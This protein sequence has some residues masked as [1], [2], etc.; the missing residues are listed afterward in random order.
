MTGALYN[1]NVTH[2][3]DLFDKGNFIADSIH[4]LAE[5]IRM[6][7]SFTK[8]IPVTSN[9]A[10]ADNATVVNFNDART[11]T[12]EKVLDIYDTAIADEE[13]RIYLCLT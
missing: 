10:D 11:T 4:V 13:R 6:N 7:F 8:N 12:I 2:N 5:T 3:R 9:S 1:Q